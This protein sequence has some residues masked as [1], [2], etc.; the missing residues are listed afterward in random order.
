LTTSLPVAVTVNNANNVKFLLHGEATE[1]SGFVDGS[2]VTP[3]VGPP[4]ILTNRGGSVNFG[5]ARVGNGVY[6]LNCC[7]LNANAYY[8][9]K[10]TQLA[11][12]FSADAGE[13][14]FNLKSRQSWAQRKTNTGHRTVLDVEDAIGDKVF[15]F[16][17]DNSDG[18][19]IRLYY[20][21]P[22]GVQ[23]YY[24]P[25]GQEDILFGNGVTMV[26]KMTWDGSSMQ[27]YLNGSL[28]Q[29]TAYSKAT[30]SWS[31]QSLF[32]FG[33]ENYLTFGAASVCDDIIDEFI[34]R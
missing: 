33:G 32:T 11:N 7:N 20:A 17:V 16:F 9:F 21:V 2:V 30:P 13:I 34:V 12:V 18:N 26:V 23:S 28:V 4:G 6:F 29:I 31:S 1:V 5:P 15:R 24:V 25:T 27:L 8:S 3:A 10:G 19:W 14:S 22:G